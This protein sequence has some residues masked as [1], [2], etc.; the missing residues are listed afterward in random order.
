MFDTVEYDRIARSDCFVCRIGA[1]KPLI[2]NPRIIYEDMP[3]IAFLNR[4]PT[5]EGSV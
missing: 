5:Q 1:G 4:F 3:V 2:A